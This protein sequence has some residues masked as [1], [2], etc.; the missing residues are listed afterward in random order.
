MYVAV[1]GRNEEREETGD[2][3]IEQAAEQRRAAH[4]HQDQ[5]R[6]I[7]EAYKVLRYPHTVRAPKRVSTRGRA[8]LNAL[9]ASSR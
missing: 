5:F 8:I 4:L 6:G 2:E 9:Y 1:K 3:Y 7:R